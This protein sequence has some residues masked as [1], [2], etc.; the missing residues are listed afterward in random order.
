MGGGSD[1]TVNIYGGDENTRVKQKQGQN[2][3]E[4][5]IYLDKKMAQL[6]SGGSA[7]AKALRA[8]YGLTQ[9]RV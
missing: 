9:R 3:P 1:V 4:I 8:S 7:T 2:G 5:D 6:V